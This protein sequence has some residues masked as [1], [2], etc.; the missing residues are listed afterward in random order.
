M[1]DSV[2]AAA[3]LQGGPRKKMKACLEIAERPVGFASFVSK[4]DRTYASSK[5]EMA[6]FCFER[7]T[8]D[9][10]PDEQRRGV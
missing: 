4:T 7:S 9:S 2:V 3:V 10:T 1:L 5:L 6:Q 8:Q